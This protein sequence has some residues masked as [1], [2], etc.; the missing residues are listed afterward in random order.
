LSPHIAR[1]LEMQRTLQ[2]PATH[3]YTLQHTATHCKILQH[4]ATH[5]KKIH[6][7]QTLRST[8][9]NIASL[10]KIQHTVQHTA[11]HCNTENVCSH[12]TLGSTNHNVVSLLKIQH[13]VQH[14]ATHCNTL[15][16]AATLR[17]CVLTTLSGPR[18]IIL[19][20]S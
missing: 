18:I 19:L 8:N 7:H 1:L 5:C 12:Y 6:S 2:H 14:T 10:L 16:H 9:R 20:A 15:Q 3:C 17:I 13:S 11:T 4:T